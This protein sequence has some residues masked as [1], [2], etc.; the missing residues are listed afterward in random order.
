MLCTS[1]GAPVRKG[2][3]ECPQCGA[4]IFARDRKVQPIYD[5]SYEKRKHDEEMF[6]ARYEQRRYRLMPQDPEE[7]DERF[8]NRISIEKTPHVLREHQLMIENRPQQIERQPGE[9]G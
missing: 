4:A 6:T 3:P 8:C 1:C 7:T 9:D 5:Q 2:I